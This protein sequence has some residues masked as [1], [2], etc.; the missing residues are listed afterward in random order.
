[1]EPA[2]EGLA[3]RRRLSFYWG[4]GHYFILAG[5]AALGAGIEVVVGAVGPHP[6]VVPLVAAYAVAVP[7]AVYVLFLWAAN[8]PLVPRI[9]IRAW[10][11]LPVVV[12][13]LLVPLAVSSLGLAVDIALIAVV[14]VFF[15]LVSVAVKVRTHQDVE[16]AG[17]ES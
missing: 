15:V 2:G 4:Y 3:Q 14:I 10:I 6:T 16:L 1:M 13:L 9:V 11:V 12:L 17:V 7:T 8:A 5:L